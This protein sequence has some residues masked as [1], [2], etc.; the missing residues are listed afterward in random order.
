MLAQ[1]LRPACSNKIA[2]AMQ[3][4]RQFRQLVRVPAPKAANV[5]TVAIVPLG[6]AGGESAELIAAG[7]DIPGFGNQ[8]DSG[9]RGILGQGLEK[10]RARVE[11]AF[12]ATE[13]GSEIEAETVDSHLNGP[14]AQAVH[15]QPQH[16]GMGNVN[17]VAATAVIDVKTPVARQQLVIAE[18]VDALVAEGGP[19]VVAFAGVVVDDIEDD[20]EAG[21]VKA[22]DHVPEF[23]RTAR[24]RDNAGCGQKKFR[25]L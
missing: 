6:P 14:I 17:G 11:A 5:I 2:R 22:V 19:E 13:N 10:R 1:G 3:A 12:L 4:A 15:D 18:I 21:V 8:L 9:E 16:L 20:F 23:V 25:L 24:R 7:A